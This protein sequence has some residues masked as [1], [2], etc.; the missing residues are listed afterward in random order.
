[1]DFTLSDEQQLIRETARDFC[2]AEITPYAAEW[3]RRETI[4]R[5]I[6]GKLGNLPDRRSY[7]RSG[8]A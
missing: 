3:D 4:D 8:A 6:V 1:M 2:A 7:R 5:S